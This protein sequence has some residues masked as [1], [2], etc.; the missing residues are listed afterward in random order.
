MNFDMKE[1]EKKYGKEKIGDFIKKIRAINDEMLTRGRELVERLY[2]LEK[3]NLFK[4]YPGYEKQR[5]QDFLWETCHIP[6]NR[7]FELRY[8]YHWFPNEAEKYGPHTIQTIKGRVGVVKLPQ[9]LKKIDQEMKA[10]KTKPEREIINRVIEKYAP[11]KEPKLTADNKTYWKT[12][13]T[14]LERKNSTLQNRVT[15]LQKEN[16]KLKEQLERQSGPVAAFLAIKD[17][18]GPML[19][20]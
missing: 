5:F 10:S 1:L 8:A 19:Q 11:I 6:Y 2:Y 17:A 9:V 3:T 7:Y 18:V 15:A 12:K 14:D 20:A 13:A 4:K 16:E